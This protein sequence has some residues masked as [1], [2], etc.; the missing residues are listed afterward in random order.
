MGE[1]LVNVYVVKTDQALVLWIYYV[2]D[3]NPIGN[4]QRIFK[5]GGFGNLNLPTSII[6]TIEFL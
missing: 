4:E 3:N 1:I 2:G 6:L 5:V